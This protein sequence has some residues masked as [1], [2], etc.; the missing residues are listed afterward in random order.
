LLSTPAPAQGGYL[1]AFYSLGVG[2]PFLLFGLAFD[3][4]L[5]FVKRI[6]RYS[7]YIY[8]ISGLLLVAM[9]FLILMNKLNWFSALY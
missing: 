6:N 5:P 8:I 9:G 4:L 3:S 1:L 2:L 7:T